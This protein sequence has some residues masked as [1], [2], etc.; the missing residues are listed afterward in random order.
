MTLAIQ[1]AFSAALAAAAST[2][3]ATAT[4]RRVAAA[5]STAPY[6]AYAM[7]ASGG[8]R[9]RAYGGS[10]AE[11]LNFLVSCVGASELQAETLSDTIGAAL[12]GAS[13]DGTFA[14]RREG[15]PPAAP[16]TPDQVRFVVNTYYRVSYIGG[17]G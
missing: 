8:P 16:V 10:Y 7:V 2:A 15:R 17:G 11:D 14:V 1:T 12:D 3:G 4:Y 5:G 13:L 6:V 9:D